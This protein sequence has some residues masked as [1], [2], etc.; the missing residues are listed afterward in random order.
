MINE[1]L[2]YPPKKRNRNKHTLI[3]LRLPVLL[4]ASKF[5]FFYELQDNR[6]RKHKENECILPTQGDLYYTHY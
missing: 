6:I 1:V 3:K 2:F 4:Q 5:N